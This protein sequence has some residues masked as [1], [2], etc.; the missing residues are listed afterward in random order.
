[1][2]RLRGL[3][4]RA[5]ALA[6]QERMALVHPDDRAATLRELTEA[7]A[8]GRLANLEFRVRWPDGQWRLIASRSAAVLDEQGRPTRRI[9]V[10][11]DITDARNAQNAR[12]EKLLAQR[13]SQA[14]SQFLSRMSHELRTPLNAVLG[15][16]QLL[17]AD[18]ERVAPDTRRRRL[19]QIHR[20]GQHLLA[21]INDVL[22]L[23]S[24]E[25]GEL[26]IGTQPVP[27]DA[28]VAETLPLVE[29]QARL[30][31]VRLRSAALAGTALADATRLRQVLLNLLTNAVKYNREGGQV[32]I[33]AEPAGDEIVLRVSDTGRGMS[34]A[35][36]QQAFEPFNRLGLESEGIE[37]T[38]IGLAIVKALVER[39]G[40][41]VQARSTPDA[42]SVF[43]VR[44]PAAHITDDVPPSD[45]T[46]DV[47]LV[48]AAPHDGR[49]GRLLYIEDNPVNLLIVQE[50]LAQRPDLELDT[51][52]D[53]LSGVRLAA[54]RVPDLILVDMQLPDI[55]GHEVLRRLRA[56]AATAEI[57]CIALS[58]NAMP[59]DIARALRAGFADYWTKPLDLQRFMRSLQAIF[60][61]P[62]R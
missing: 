53:G 19:E 49:P 32:L 52:V 39:M 7:T 47:A 27:L 57:P 10:N 41:T 20:A 26:R 28:L 22:E 58:A 24:L 15:F 56:D 11:W 37:G 30:H 6:E 31:K 17:L 62:A 45:G 3:Q 38:G 54:Q 1:M 12:E 25:G 16:A 9:G 2:W 4:P 60:G 42:G 14:K 50:L 13:E 23:S 59:D 61:D 48:P 18:G 36:L 55:D 34:E 29:R 33:E 51:A 35:Q 5:Q 44:L 40:G 43:E 46:S 8:E 21:L